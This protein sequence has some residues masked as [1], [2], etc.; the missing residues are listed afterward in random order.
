MGENDHFLVY[1][2]VWS[3]HEG[4]QVFAGVRSAAG[5]AGINQ[6]GGVFV[7]GRP[8]PD[9]IRR[10]I[11]ELALMGVRPCDISRQLL[12]S[13]GCVSKI[14]TRFYET[15]SIKPGSIG[16]SKPKVSNP[17]VMRRMLRYKNDTGPSGW[18]MRQ[19][20]PHQS[21]Q[22]H[23][24]QHQPQPD[25]PM[26]AE[27]GLA[28]P[29][30]S[31]SRVLR[32][33]AE[34]SALSSP[35]VDVTGGLAEP[36]PLAMGPYYPSPYLA[37]QHVTTCLPALPQ[38]P[39]QQHP[40]TRQ[41]QQH[42]QQHPLQQNGLS[43][44]ALP[45]TSSAMFATS[46]C[47]TMTRPSTSHNSGGMLFQKKQRSR[48]DSNEPDSE[49]DL[50]DQDSSDEQL[51]SRRRNIGGSKGVTSYSIEEILKKPG[52][53]P[54]GRSRA[55]YRRTAAT[56]SSD[57]AG[58]NGT[59][60]HHSKG[61]SKSEQESSLEAEV[62]SSSAD[63][64]CNGLPPAASQQQQLSDQTTTAAAAAA[65]AAAAVAAFQPQAAALA[66]WAGA[67]ASSPGSV[68][69]A[70]F[71]FTR[72]APMMAPFP[73][74]YFS[75]M[76]AIYPHAQ[77]AQP[78]SSSVE[79]AIAVDSNIVADSA[80]SPSPAAETPPNSAVHPKPSSLALTP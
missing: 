11:V 27:H 12:V 77:A 6:L 55:S 44:M 33:A 78:S 5:Q 21:P 75:Q 28:S 52:D 73:C 40:Q 45:S 70:S 10:R 71:P 9:Y 14:L 59:S 46:S 67:A 16:G 51:P 54:S 31:A 43:Q 42:Q 69:F 50:E 15:G 47:A 7:N 64:E 1:G 3:T 76:A 66:L 48:P 32:C 65:A 29:P 60:P 35:N 25:H 58:A 30:P 34:C 19:L 8:L 62:T 20:L 53:A 23:Q 63:A 57:D 2:D 74:S 17:Q 4:N 36:L 61:H 72:F 56:W 79:P 80:T 26:G 18:D 22:Q 49:D 13:H 24:Q 37:L 39:P 41:A 38:Q 68:G